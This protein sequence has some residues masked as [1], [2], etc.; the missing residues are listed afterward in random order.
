MIYHQTEERAFTVGKFVTFGYGYYS[1]EL[2]NKELLVFEEIDKALLQ[3]YDL[4]TGAYEGR[5]F[6]VAYSI[7]TEDLDDEDFVVLRL[8]DLTMVPKGQ[9]SSQE[10]AIQL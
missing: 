3:K 5:Y 7:L 2:G 10:E 4:R 8:N 9:I 1:F 6:E